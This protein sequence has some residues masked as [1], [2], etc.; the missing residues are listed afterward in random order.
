VFQWPGECRA[1]KT[2]RS[3]YMKQPRALPLHSA[4]TS[5]E[6]RFSV[7]QAINILLTRPEELSLAPGC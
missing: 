1:I 7:L 3:L 5:L 4:S 6:L 2:P